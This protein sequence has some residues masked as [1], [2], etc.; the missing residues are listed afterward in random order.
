MVVRAGIA[1]SKLL[2]LRGETTTKHASHR[3]I[4]PSEECLYC[5]RQGGRNI[6]RAGGAVKKLRAMETYEEQKNRYQLCLLLFN[7]NVDL[8]SNKTNYRTFVSIRS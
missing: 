1:R 4:P 2:Q 3:G 5:R 7:N 6:G 8:K